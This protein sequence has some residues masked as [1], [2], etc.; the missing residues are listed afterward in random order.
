MNYSAE[1]K[2]LYIFFLKHACIERDQVFLYMQGFMIKII[3]YGHH[4]TERQSWQNSL[5]QIQSW[6]WLCVTI[7]GIQ[8]HADS[9]YKTLFFSLTFSYCLISFFVFFISIFGIEH[10]LLKSK[11]EKKIWLI[12]LSNYGT[13]NYKQPNKDSE[14]TN[15][16]VRKKTW[17]HISEPCMYTHVPV[18]ILFDYIYI[19]YRLM[20]ILYH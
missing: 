20:N 16:T 5:Q 6:I 19:S 10:F 4:N 2:S 7:T 1:S 15:K 12:F 11:I 18:H 8:K 17:F 14:Q 3:I 9:E 13:V